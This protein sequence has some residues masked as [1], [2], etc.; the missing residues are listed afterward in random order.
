MSVETVFTRSKMVRAKYL[1]LEQQA[2]TLCDKMKL[3]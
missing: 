1:N 2:G 3:P